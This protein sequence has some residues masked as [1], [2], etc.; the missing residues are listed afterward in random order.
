MLLKLSE[1]YA[2]A[3]LNEMFQPENI[4]NKQP[5][6]L[7]TTTT[8]NYAENARIINLIY[9]CNLGTLLGNIFLSI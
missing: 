3:S 4:H 1:T 9:K 8:I 5:D 6:K 7:F 2:D